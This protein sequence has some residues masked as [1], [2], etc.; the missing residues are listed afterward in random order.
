MALCSQSL[1]TTECE[2]QHG[3]D[4]GSIF[5]AE[6]GDDVFDGDDEEAVV[7]FEIDG[8]GVLWVEEDAIVL[9]DGVAVVVFFEER[10][11]GDDSAGDGGDFNFVGEVDA[12]LGL[13]FV[14]IFADEDA[15]AE[16]FNGFET[17]AG[18]GFGV[19]HSESLEWCGQ[20]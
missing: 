6:H 9:V 4:G 20:V 14:L 10:G 17:S 2:E 7:A 13:L 15:L 1:F 18:G 11:D 5:L 12:G 8:D 19:G 16:G 3:A